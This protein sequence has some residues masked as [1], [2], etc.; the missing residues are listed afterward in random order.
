MDIETMHIAVKQEL[1]KTSALEL[2]AFL[3][4]EIDF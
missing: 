2:P 4:E 1:D 3:P